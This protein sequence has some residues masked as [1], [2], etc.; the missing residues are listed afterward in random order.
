L[1]EI[2][3]KELFEIKVLANLNAHPEEVIVYLATN[4]LEN[5]VRFCNLITNNEIQKQVRFGLPDDLGI[6]EVRTVRKIRN[7]VYIFQNDGNI[8]GD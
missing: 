8:T 2:I 1:I 4:G 3:S 6:L 7:R 5:V